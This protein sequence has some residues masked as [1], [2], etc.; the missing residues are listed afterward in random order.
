MI[1]IDT[2]PKAPCSHMGH[3]WAL[4]GF[5]YQNFGVYVYTG[6]YDRILSP[7]LY[8]KTPTRSLRFETNYQ[9]PART[10]AWVQDLLAFGVSQKCASTSAVPGSGQA[11]GQP[12]ERRA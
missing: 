11:K 1:S 3:T 2:S 9:V 5:T 12:H 6:R 4:K 7:P 8:V 10:K